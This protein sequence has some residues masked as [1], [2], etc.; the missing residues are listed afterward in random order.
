M[1]MAVSFDR[2]LHAGTIVDRQGA[3]R[4]FG[5]RFLGPDDLAELV[6]F[7]DT[8]F[9]GL[10]DIDAYFPEVPEFAAWHLAE[11]GRTLGVLSEGRLIGCAVIGVPRTGMPNFS[12]DIPE[13]GVPPLVVTHLC[14]CMIDP[15]VRGNG[16]QRLLVS[17]RLMVALG[18]GRPHV[19]TRVAVIN[20]ISL[21]NMLAC[22]LVLRRIIVMHGTR[23]RYV[24]HGDFSAPNV[25]WEP[26]QEV[27]AAASDIE[28]QKDLLRQ[29]LVGVAARGKGAAGELV[30]VPDQQGREAGC[31]AASSSSIHIQPAL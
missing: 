30:F 2:I 3:R 10:P 4:S 12:D 8:I 20:R 17:L 15:L 7:R 5:V 23:L 27:T 25:A 28:R 9:A 22:G 18:L 19:F 31:G 1:T 13:L 14:S 21:A 24:L 29:G 11:R 16:L 26:R 6:S